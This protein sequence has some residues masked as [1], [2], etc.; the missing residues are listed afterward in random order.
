MP[1]QKRFTF[2]VETKQGTFLGASERW[3]FDEIV[4][5][6]NGSMLVRLNTDIV[7]EDLGSL[8]NLMNQLTI[9]ISSP[10]T[11]STGIDYF[12]GYFPRRS[13]L[14]TT[15]ERN[16]VIPAFGHASRLWEM[17][18]EDRSVGGQG[19]VRDFTSSGSTASNIVK[20][21]IDKVRAID[22]NYV[23]NYNSLSVGN[24]VDTV[25]DKFAAVKAG[26]ALNR[27]VFLAF[28]ANKIWHWLVR[29]DNI[30]HFKAADL[31]SSVEPDHLFT[32][33]RDIEGIPQLE[34]D[35][36]QAANDILV[37][38]NGG[39]AVKRVDDSANITAYGRRTLP[40]VHEDGIPDA[41]TAAE[42]A[43]AYLESYKP[44]LRT[45]RMTVTDT[46]NNGIENID[47][48]DTC[49]ILNL[50]KDVDNI[51]GN[52][53]ILITKTIYRKDVVELELSLKHPQIESK[54]E[55]IRRRFDQEQS[56]GIPNTYS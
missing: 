55:Q 9:T 48:G 49:R 3:D 43:N 30:F 19:I 15:D 31:S 23:V 24:S 22:T 38:Y 34:E 28:D 36:T 32:Y 21:I 5:E 45:V 1:L 2:K 40:P 33:G 26:D 53:N 46:Y 18:Y 47:P 14:L 13:L 35:L 51:L 8:A 50:P 27:C 29:G 12:S 37:V 25:K 41:T 44:P 4:R 16:V 56:Q 11:G 10:T 52:K 7:V 54:V 42:V 17:L 20:D 39:A 6:L